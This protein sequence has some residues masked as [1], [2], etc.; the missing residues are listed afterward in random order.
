M[1]VRE[2]ISLRVPA[3]VDATDLQ[4]PLE[5]TLGGVVTR[6]ENWGLLEAVRMVLGRTERS[7][8]I[9]RSATTVELQ[10]G[11]LKR[12]AAL[13]VD[14][15]TDINGD[16]AGGAVQTRYF[17]SLESEAGRREEYEVDGRFSGKAAP[18]DVGVAYFKG[19]YLVDFE[20]IPV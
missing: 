12:V 16:G 17:A 19:P 10:R 4:T 5:R 20:R 9:Q 7:Q 18:G 13:I 15:R 14:E 6:A 3:R 1:L 2:G 8:R 11:E